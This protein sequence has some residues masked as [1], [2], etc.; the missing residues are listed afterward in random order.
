MRTFVRRT[1]MVCA[2]ILAVAFVTTVS[3]DLGP[4]LRSQA[5][6]QGTRFMERP[7]H[8][9]TMHV[10]LW[11][12]AYVFEDLRI[13]GLKPEST[14]FFTAKRIVVSMP[15]STLFNRRVVFDAIEL[16]DWQMHVETLRDGTHNFPKLTPRGPARTQLVD[17]DAAVREG[18]PRAVHVSG[19]QHAVGDRR[20]EPGR[21]A[22]ASG[23][24]STSGRRA[25]Q[26]A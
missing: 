6:Q 8:I 5:E 15:W 20:E 25:F 1:V 11:D 23:Q 3:V 12:G 19:P 24:A 9:G 2:V 22:G 4:L 13:D 17:H 10:R 21:H 7:L 14:P 26:T 16:T 18:R